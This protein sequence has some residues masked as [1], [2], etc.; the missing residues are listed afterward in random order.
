MWPNWWRSYYLESGCQ[1]CKNVRNLKIESEVHIRK[2]TQSS[3]CCVSSTGSKLAPR[4]EARRGVSSSCSGWHGL[5]RTRPGP[6]TPSQ[7]PKPQGQAPK[8][9]CIRPRE[10]YVHPHSRTPQRGHNPSPGSFRL[11][12]S[13]PEE[14][15]SHSSCQTKILI[16]SGT[17]AFYNG[18]V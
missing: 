6:G 17:G 12:N 5:V 3:S 11:I 18:K 8:K 10:K 7:A 16:F 15:R 14:G 4:T 9:Y 2:T 1:C 13:I